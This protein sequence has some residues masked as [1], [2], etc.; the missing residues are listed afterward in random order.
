MNLYLFFN[1]DIIEI[2]YDLYFEVVFLQLR[3]EEY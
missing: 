1:V 2:I 3:K